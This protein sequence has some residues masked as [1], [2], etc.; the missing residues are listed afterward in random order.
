HSRQGVTARNHGDIMPRRLPESHR[1]LVSLCRAGKG[2][3]MNKHNEKFALGAL[4]AIIGLGLTWA[5]VRLLAASEGSTAQ[6]LRRPEDR[7]AIEELFAAY[8]ATLDRRDFDAFGKLF[9]E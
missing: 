6:R 7:E 5:P 8:G 1:A 9:T 3:A 4:L 2:E